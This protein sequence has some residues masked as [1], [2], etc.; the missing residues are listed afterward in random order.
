MSFSFKCKNNHLYYFFSDTEIPFC[1]SFVIPLSKMPSK[2]YFVS[3][4]AIG[5]IKELTV[6]RFQL[7]PLQLR[8]L[9]QRALKSG[10]VA[11]VLT[12]S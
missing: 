12:F 11:E 1:L 3:L 9:Y 8:I 7:R 10:L 5:G 2:R 6:Q 4:L